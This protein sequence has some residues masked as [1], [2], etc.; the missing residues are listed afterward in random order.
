MCL[1]FVFYI[2]MIFTPRQIE[3]IL[4]IIDKYHLIFTAQHVG[5]EV[6]SP[7]DKALLRGYGIDPD[8]LKKDSQ[9]EHAFKFGLLSYSLS[10][11]DAKK[12]DYPSFKRFLESG[13]FIPLNTR[14]NDALNAL[15]FHAYSDITGL[16]NKIKDNWNTTLIE[17][18]QKQRAKYEK[19]VQDEA[20]RTIRNR[21]SVRD[22]VSR[23][24][25]QTGD[26][27]RDFGRISDYVLH[28]AFDHG[29][30]MSIERDGGGSSL[31]YKDVYPGACKHCIQHYLTAGIGSQPKIFKLSELQ[32][33]GTNVGR[34]VADWQPVIGP[35]HP[36][37]RCTLERVPEGYKWNDETQS[38]STPSENYQRKVQ[39][40]S[41]IRVTVGDTTTEV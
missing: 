30:A 1:T 29:R 38:F 32:A 39:R 12:L 31:V 19:I 35:L 25:H 3:E 34:K 15:K 18:D 41:K 11:Q 9:L 7:N 28:S 10:K 26:W 24:G 14:E 23:L 8:K 36:W 2:D 27:S 21:E 37:C 40:K 33:N 4:K 13:G 6:L 22:M 20:E 16:G 5:F 17:A